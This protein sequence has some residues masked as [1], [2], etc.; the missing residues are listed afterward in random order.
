[1]DSF[2]STWVVPPDHPAFA[3]HFP[4]QPIVPGVVLLDHAIALAGQWLQRPSAGWR[5]DQAKF[6]QPVGPGAVLR[7]VFSRKPS[8]T[9]A[10]TVT[11]G[12]RSVASGALTPAGA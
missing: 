7:F 11:E 9:V 12:D 1:M 10:Y 8:G 2:E 5:V 6:L 3:G 4:G